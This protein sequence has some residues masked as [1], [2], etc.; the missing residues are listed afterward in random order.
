MQF[1][2]PKRIHLSVVDDARAARPLP[3][4]TRVQPKSGDKNPVLS[5]TPSRD[6]RV[7]QTFDKGSKLIRQDVQAQ[8]AK[9]KSK[10]K[11]KAMKKAKAKPIP[12]TAGLLSLHG[13]A[14]FA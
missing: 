10:A 12:R 13:N 2:P 1:A 7:I 3:T 14:G 8:T 6:C 9:A 5:A 11:S 4:P